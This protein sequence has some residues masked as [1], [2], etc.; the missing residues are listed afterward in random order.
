MHSKKYNVVK[1]YYDKGFWTKDMVYN[2]VGKGWIT[3]EEYYEIVGTQ[4]STQHEPETETTE[5]VEEEVE[6]K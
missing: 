6:E 4:S 3:E 1:N 2:A 5:V